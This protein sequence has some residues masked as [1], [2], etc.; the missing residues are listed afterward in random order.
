M[1]I[2]QECARK[3]SVAAGTRGWTRGFNPPEDA[4]VPSMLEDE[5]SC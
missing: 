1:K 3:Q 5:Q 2:A 4:H